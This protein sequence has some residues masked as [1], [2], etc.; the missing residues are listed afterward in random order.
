MQAKA[1]A[2]RFFVPAQQARQ[3]LQGEAQT[4]RDAV[5]GAMSALGAE[6]RTGT[7][8]LLASIN[9]L[10]EAARTTVQATERERES[11][12]QAIAAY[13]GRPPEPGKNGIHK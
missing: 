11:L 6:A 2:V 9:N 12:R 7:A 3:A 5:V 13:L 4:T 8:N 1:R 10:G